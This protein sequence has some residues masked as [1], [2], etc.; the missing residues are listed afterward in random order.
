MSDQT[1]SLNKLSPERRALLAL[2]ALRLKGA[3]P[4]RTI[5][6][7][8]RGE[9]ENTFPL[10]AAQER[11]WF[12][13]QLVPGSAAFNLSISM[14][15]EGALDIGALGESLN[16]MARRHE[17]LRTS[18]RNDGGRPA[19][20]VAPAPDVR[21]KV[22]DLR[23][24]A[25]AAGEARR[26]AVEEVSRPF[27]L[28]ANALMR[29]VLLRL[30]EREQ[31]LLV[32]F[33]HVVFD[34]W[35]GG[36]FIRELAS[37]YEALTRGRPVQLPELPVQ[38]ADFAVW[39][40]EWMRGDEYRAQLDYWKRKLGGELPVL[41]LP[42]DRPRPLTQTSNG[43]Q[44]TW[45]APRTLL[46]ALSALG[47]REGATLYMT[48]LAAFKVLL[49]RYTGQ[50][51]ILVGSPIASR[52][53]SELEGLVG[54]FINSLVLRT[55]LGGAISFR[56]ALGRVRRTVLDAYA[57]QDVPFNKLI[58]ELRPDRDAGLRQPLHQVGFS[59]QNAPAPSI[60][61]AESELLLTQFPVDAPVE[62]FEDLNFFVTETADGLAGTVEYNTDLFEPLTIA[63]LIGH[64]RQLLDAVVADPDEPLS[65]LN[66]LPAEERRQLLV[67][68]NQT[69]ADYP[70]E[71]CLHELFEEQA[72]RT[73]AAA[74][75]VFEGEHLT[76]AELDARANQLARHVRRLGAGPE[77]V[78]GIC[79]ERSASM[80]VAALGAL[81][82][83][84]AYLMLDP[85]YP[86][87]R[88]SLMLEDSGASVLVTEAAL[89][90]REFARGLRTVCLDADREL[91][92]R[93]SGEK[94][95][96]GATADNLA[97]VIYTSGSTGRPKGSGLPHRALTNLVSWHAAS[98]ARGTRTV[99]FAS[100][101]FDI[102]PLRNLLDV[103]HGRDVVRHSGGASDRPRRA[104]ALRRRTSRRDAEPP[105]RRVAA[106]G[107]G[108]L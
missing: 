44:Q 60:R 34:M 107:R 25:D 12:L 80:V 81:K 16:E 28:S 11:L 86:P 55:D 51:D 91:I 96:G 13:D 94:F 6:R 53:R 54:F 57:N 41:E 9:G 98:V 62:T 46:S 14:R 31:V 40:R 105:R 75:V 71:A 89:R 93:A 63:R 29:T 87:E 3:A 59:L 100:L 99:Q 38:Y 26:V 69:R 90:G 83:G 95:V 88:L 1:S 61:L 36:I 85:T 70:R 97:Y 72:Q 22:L 102:E 33:H 5:P 74:A 82:A 27:D 18:L 64:Y 67:N 37:F 23:G 47:E 35:S 58:Q 30:G 49:C 20:V 43:A 8:P 32:I 108:V 2:R 104:R 66:I 52:S 42:A 106:V 73:P 68:W 77:S 48:L 39:Q 84:G 76:Y 50:T 15:I 79:V 4:E 103:L 92:A 10:S 101:S 45:K 17:I 21:L 78:V 65:R 56:A 7:L 24:H 19:Q